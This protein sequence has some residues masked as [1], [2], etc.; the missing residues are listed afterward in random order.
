MTRSRREYH[1]ACPFSSRIAHHRLCKRFPIHSEYHFRLLAP[2]CCSRTNVCSQTIGYLIFKEHLPQQ[3]GSASEA[4]FR[5]K[6]RRIFKSLNLIKISASPDCTQ[7]GPI[8]VCKSAKHLAKSTAASPMKN[9]LKSPE[10][11]TSGYHLPNAEGT[12]QIYN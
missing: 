10:R 8:W 7:D 5:V 1:Y 12:D 4:S 2:L 6:S 3:P 9:F 11:K